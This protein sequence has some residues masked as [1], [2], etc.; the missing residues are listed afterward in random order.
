MKELFEAIGARFSDEVE[1]VTDLYNTIAKPSAVF[2]YVVFRLVTGL[3][4]GTLNT[5]LEDVLIQFNIYDGVI[6]S[7]NVC[8]IFESISAA[9]DQKVIPIDNYEVQ[10][11]TRLELPFTLNKWEENGRQVWDYMT[12]YNFEIV[13]T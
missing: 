1:G 5:D 4:G 3:S 8:D 10:R 11:I 12:Q 7:K 13:R 6:S 9:F 2:P